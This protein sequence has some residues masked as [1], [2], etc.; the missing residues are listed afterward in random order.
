MNI[1]GSFSFGG[2]IKTLIPGLILLS[3]ILI[4]LDII[5]YLFYD[6]TELLVAISEDTGVIVIISIPI[7]IF[8][9]ATLNSILFSGLSEKM[10]ENKHKKNNEQFYK[11]REDI[12]EFIKLKAI[13]NYALT[14]NNRATFMKSVDPRFVLLSRGSYDNIMYL[15]ESYW[16][17]MEFQL[18]S[19]VAVTMG[20]P[21][22]IGKVCILSIQHTLGLMHPVIISAAIVVGYFIFAIFFIRSAEDNLNRHREKELSYLIGIAH[23]ALSDPKQKERRYQFEFTKET[24]L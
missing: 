23:F 12:F 6:Y 18:N 4:Y 10:I 1:F 15:R 17:H 9:G 8:L 19:L 20:V 24:E 14:E 16:Y 2:L 5:C 7:A 13:S 3:V 21:A 22:F 11:L